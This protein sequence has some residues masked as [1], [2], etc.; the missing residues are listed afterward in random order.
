MTLPVFLS[1]ALL[2]APLAGAVRPA[3]K[4]LD[5]ENGSATR[6]AARFGCTAT[7]RSTLATTR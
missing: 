3:V 6:R 5:T 4:T 1:R 7:F 2:C